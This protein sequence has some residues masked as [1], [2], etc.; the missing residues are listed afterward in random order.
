MS[1]FKWL[2]K[3]EVISLFQLPNTRLPGEYYS[4]LSKTGSNVIKK[5]FFF[6]ISHFLWENMKWQTGWVFP[7]QVSLY[8][9]Q[10]N[11]KHNLFGNYFFDIL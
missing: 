5:K 4:E 11:R 6:L 8:N 2:Q 10:I 1:V 7:F 3:A 9:A